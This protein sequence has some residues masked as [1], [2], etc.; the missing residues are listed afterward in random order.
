MQISSCGSKLFLTAAAFL[1]GK[2][3]DMAY[4]G[5]NNIYE[6]AIRRMVREALEQ[7]EAAFRQAHGQDPDE[8]LLAY[9][10]SRAAALGHTPWP[11]EI[12]GGALI[13]QR[14][15]TWERALA[16]ARLPAPRTPNQPRSFARVRA[17][18]EKQ[19]EIYR[20]HKAEKQA[21]SAQRRMEQAAKK[22]RSP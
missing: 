13:R 17:E 7:Q 14:F 18:T 8:Q 5:R 9:L 16:L 11:G 21:R 10:H 15:G 22:K 20:Q 6:A 3:D 2:E 1:F 19:K 12:L 4:P